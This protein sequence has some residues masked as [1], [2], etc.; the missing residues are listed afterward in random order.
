MIL[1]RILTLAALL[2][3]LLL[4]AGAHAEPPIQRVKQVDL[5]RYM[6]RWYVIAS[7]PSRVE[8]GGHNAVETY[9]LQA[10]GTVC[11]WFRLR[12]GSFDA[13]V[14]LIRSTASIIPGSGQAQ[15]SVHLYWLLRLQY[16]V[17]WLSPDYS[18]VMVVRDARDYLWYMARSPQVSDADYL[19]MLARAK[20]MGYDPA[21]IEKVPQRWPEHVADN[22]TFEGACP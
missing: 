22:Q 2:A 7:I 10:D 18:Q 3:A 11:T 21:R 4:G 5:S 8:R 13:P 17:G 1:P 9:R 14:R 16:L 20:A 6:G 12:P 15:W 19:G